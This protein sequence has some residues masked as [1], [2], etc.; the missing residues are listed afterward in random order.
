M[1][2]TID[3]RPYFV[4]Q[5]LVIN[6]AIVGLILV[7]IVLTHNPLFIMGL[8]LLQNMPFMSAEASQ[9]L[10]QLQAGEV[11]E[12]DVEGEEEGQPMGFTADVK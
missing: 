2:V 12:E 4:H 6:L 5:A 7:G 3:F 1:S 11:E 8:L 10:A 9:L